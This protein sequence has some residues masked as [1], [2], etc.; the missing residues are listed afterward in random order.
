VPLGT[1]TVK[2]TP[3]IRALAA[4]EWRAYRSL[5]LRALEDSPDA[6]GSTLVAERDREDTWWSARLASGAGSR[7]DLPLVAEVG[8]EGVGLAWGRI[9][10]AQR[11]VANLYQMWVDPGYRGRGT[12][13]MLLDAVVS[14]ARDAGARLLA[15]GV[16]CGDTPAMRLYA[17]AGFHRVGEP[18]PIRPGSPLLGQS[19]QLELRGRAGR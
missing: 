4:G 19:M 13:G 3:A 8:V 15:L 2:P 6:F 11:D 16:T 10:P 5:R 1:Q 18:A 12:G 14:W 7:L 9:D 17:R